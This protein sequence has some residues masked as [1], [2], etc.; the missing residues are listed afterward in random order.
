MVPFDLEPRTFLFSFAAFLTPQSIHASGPL[1]RGDVGVDL[2][3]DR[4]RVA[5]LVLDEPQA[6]GFLVEVG[7]VGV[8]AG[9]DRKVRGE[10]CPL[11]RSLKKKLEAPGCELSA[12]LGN[13][14]IVL[15]FCG[16]FEALL[17]GDEFPEVSFEVLRQGDGPV[18][19]AL[20]VGNELGLGPIEGE[21]RDSDLGDLRNTEAG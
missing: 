20:T 1:L 2:G 12:P 21:V 19:F 18:L 6:L 9:M 15:G 8:P 14:E 5:E 17:P 11:G 3:D 13:K 7:P 16:L 4:R 10:A